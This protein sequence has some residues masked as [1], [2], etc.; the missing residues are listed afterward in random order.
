MAGDDPQ[1]DEWMELAVPAVPG[2][3]AYHVHVNGN[4]D[5]AVT[6]EP[7]GEGVTLAVYSDGTWIV[8]GQEWTED[9][10]GC[11]DNDPAG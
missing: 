9:P 11:G 7:M 4:P 1:R 6:I 10:C 8:N 2:A 5:A 3:L